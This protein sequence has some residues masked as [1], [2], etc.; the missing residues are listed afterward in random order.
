MEFLFF[1]DNIL[2]FKGLNH[3]NDSKFDPLLISEEY[4]IYKYNILSLNNKFK[5]GVKQTLSLK[6]SFLIRPIYSPKTSLKMLNNKWKYKNIYNHYSCFCKGEI[7]FSKLAKEKGQTCKYK[8]YLSIIDQNKY[9][10]N[11]TDYLLSDFLFEKLSSDDAYPIFKEMLKRN[12]SAHYMT[13]KKNIYK[14]FCGSNEHCQIIINEIFINGDFLEKYLELILKLKVAIFGNGFLSIDY[15]IFHNIEY[16]TSINLGHGVKYFKSFLYKE[17]ANPR[18]YDKLVLIPSKKVINV[19]LRYGWKE[20]NIIK[21]CLPK[22]DKYDKNKDKEI[23]KSIFIFFTWRKLKKEKNISSEYTYNIIKLI[24][25]DILN[26]KLIEKNISLYYCLHHKFSQYKNMIKINKLKLKLN[27]ITNNQI[28]ETLMK[29]SLLITDFSSV[30]FDFIYKR[31]PIIIYIPDSEDPS[32][33]D[34]YD[35]NYIKLINNMKNGKMHFENI[36]NTTE[37]VIN[38]IIFYVDNNFELESNMKKFYNSFGL[39][40]GNNTRFFIDYIQKMK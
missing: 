17:N 22:W 40:C 25:S 39:K 23:G 35:I 13:Q 6:K 27:Y 26:K 31:K 24:N 1:T 36:Y 29:S 37:Q 15:S 38:K 21:V 8:I 7:C 9:L 18:Q 32:I 12:I 34:N 5:D 3:L 11:K 14:E 2:N 20:E 10:Y 33:K 19:A 28:S 30:I 16:I 4:H